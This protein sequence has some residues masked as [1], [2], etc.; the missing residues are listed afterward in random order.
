MPRGY[1]TASAW[2]AVVLPDA[3]T[4]SRADGDGGAA[5]DPATDPGTT[6]VTRSNAPCLASAAGHACAG[7][8]PSRAL[9]YTRGKHRAAARADFLHALPAWQVRLA[10]CAHRSVQHL[11]LREV[12]FA[13][14]HAVQCALKGAMAACKV[15]G[16]GV[17]ALYY[18]KLIGIRPAAYPPARCS[19]NREA[20]C[21]RCWQWPAATAHPR[22]RLPH[23]PVSPPP[24]QAPV[25]APRSM[26]RTPGAGHCC[27]CNP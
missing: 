4:D 11:P 3:S 5:T 9:L 23:V 22:L 2:S 10:A 8:L 16:V 7:Q 15:L 19:S 14:K 17:V 24:P 26:P 27:H 20:F 12:Q 25:P 6:A 13:G 18:P 1:R 21:R